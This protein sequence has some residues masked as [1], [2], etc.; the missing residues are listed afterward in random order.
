M[1]RIRRYL[2]LFAGKNLC[3]K[4]QTQE[5][6][7][8]HDH[9]LAPGIAENSIG[10]P[11]TTGESQ[12]TGHLPEAGSPLEFSVWFAEGPT[13]DKHFMSYPFRWKL[14]LL[15][16]DPALVY[17]LFGS[18]LI[19][20]I[21]RTKYSHVL[22]EYDGVVLDP[23]FQKNKYWEASVFKNIY[24]GSKCSFKMHCVSGDPDL[25][26]YEDNRD[27]GALKTSIWGTFFRLVSLFTF[28][29]VQLDQDCVS[30]ATGIIRRCTKHKVPRK[31][32]T[33]AQLM[34]WL[35]EVG[36]DRTTTIAPNKRGAVNRR[37]R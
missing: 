24:P 20:K 23:T 9:S 8:S 25:G 21:T 35:E 1:N 6:L 27:W 26:S 22:I 17:Y 16:R 2:N 37:V 31:I 11:K 5:G 32:F 30:V 7:A 10:S 28:G 19:K 15:R 29:S 34:R 13:A 3:E 4:Q 12:C 33:P 36:Y 18:E 14:R